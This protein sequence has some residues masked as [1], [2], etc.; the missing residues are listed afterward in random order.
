[1]TVGDE[2]W[3]R[4]GRPRCSWLGLVDVVGQCEYGLSALC[5]GDG[6]DLGFDFLKQVLKIIDLQILMMS[7]LQENLVASD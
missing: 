4:E 3:A 6:S 5:N 1:M 2:L 7:T